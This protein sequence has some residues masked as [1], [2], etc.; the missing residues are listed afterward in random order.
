MEGSN[1]TRYNG[2][3]RA[4][5]TTTARAGV[6]T[7]GRAATSAQNRCPERCGGRVVTARHEA[8][9]DGCGIVVNDVRLDTGPTSVGRKHLRGGRI[10]WA[11]EPTTAFRV[12]GGLRTKIG[13]GQDARGNWLSNDKTRQLR[14]LRRQ[15]KRLVGR[16]DRV[17]EA[18]R[19]VDGIG[20]NLGIPEYVRVDAARLVHV[21]K[22]RRL[23]CGRLSWEAL[24]GGA[25]LLAARNRLEAECVPS[26]EEVARYTKATHER[27][28]AAAR[29]IR[30]GGDRHDM[31][32]GRPQAVEAI[33]EQVGG[34]FGP[35]E[36]PTVARASQRLLELADE[37]GI[38]PG[39]SRVT[40]ATVAIDRATLLLGMRPFS[41]VEL[42]DA[43]STVVETSESRVAGYSVELKNALESTDSVAAGRPSIRLETM[44]G[45]P[46]RH[47][48]APGHG[49]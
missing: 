46:D 34:G 35:G 8:F 49:R 3:D 38:G 29:K 28:C 36:R 21:A 42:V 13:R 23:P 39:T 17:T 6:E 45:E 26:P 19:D 37:T 2:S 15:H 9:C 31:P 41:R 44:L 7:N 5:T 43:A 16:N 10:K 27:T 24:A 4:T 40:M 1:S 22:E 48:V 33:L 47:D 18:L 12:D 30:I 32:P 11:R 14:R 25:I 20:A